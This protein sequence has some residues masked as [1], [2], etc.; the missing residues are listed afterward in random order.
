MTATPTFLRLPLASFDASLLPVDARVPGSPQF[1]DAVAKHFVERYAAKGERAAVAVGDD[2]IHVVVG[3]NGEDPSDAVAVMLRAGR[4]ADAVPFLEAL[5]RARPDDVEGLYNLGIAHSELGHYEEAVAHLKRAVEL[6]PKHAHAWSGLGV[7]CQRLGQSDLALEAMRQAVDADREDGYA[8]RNLGG[9]LLARGQAE[10]ALGH[11]RR[12]RQAL[13]H[14]VQATYG[15]ATALEEVGGDANLEEAD[16][17]YQVVLERWPGSKPA[18]LARQARTRIAERQMR[19]NVGGGLRP[20]AVM[21]MLDALHRFDTMSKPDVQRLA[22]EIALKGRAGSTSTIRSRITRCGR[23][24]ASSRA[25]TSCRSCTPRSG[26]SI[27]R[28]TRASTCAAST[29]P[30]SRLMARGAER[31]ALARSVGLPLIVV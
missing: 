1:R 10:E 20:D 15:L 6:A 9:V 3:A 28:W 31:V 8:R 24:R 17:L 4:I 12:A 26:E 16:E 18:E 14:D 7:A 19:S 2:E 23:C 27:R 30:R 29:T 13:P 5:V 21:Y 22:L 11:L 25:C